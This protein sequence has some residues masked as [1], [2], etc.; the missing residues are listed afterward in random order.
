[1][2]KIFRILDKIC[3]YHVHLQDATAARERK[4][5]FILKTKESEASK[6]KFLSFCLI[7]KTNIW[8]TAQI[9]I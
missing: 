6:M 1:M 7:P 8:N 5:S 3:I 4:V 9:S 2:H